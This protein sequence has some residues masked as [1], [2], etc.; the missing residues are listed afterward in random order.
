MFVPAI[1]LQYHEKIKNMVTQFNA[2]D[3]T[4]FAKK[5]ADDI[6]SGRKQADPDGSYPVTHADFE[7]WKFE[8][9]SKDKVVR[10]KF[11]CTQIEPGADE[12]YPTNVFMAPCIEGSPENKKFSEYTPSGQFTLGIDKKADALK[13]FREGQEYYLD[14]SLAN[15]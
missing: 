12:S 8:K 7:N 3:M 9:E 2:N 14:I 10:A 1:L 13:F 4:S 11:E 15:K 6:E 5:I